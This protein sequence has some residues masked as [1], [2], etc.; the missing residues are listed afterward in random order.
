[1]QKGEQPLSDADLKEFLA[2]EEAL[3]TQ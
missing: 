1:M 3:E 2:E